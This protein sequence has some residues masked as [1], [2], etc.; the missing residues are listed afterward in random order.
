MRGG[1]GGGGRGRTEERLLPR[2]S[3]SLFMVSRS[4]AQRWKEGA[5]G[6]RRESDR[7][8]EREGGRRESILRE[9]TSIPLGKEVE[10]V[11]EDGGGRWGP[12]GWWSLFSGRGP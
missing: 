9:M 3:T 11:G 7:E 6:R 1:E 10:E 5:D 4:S 2:P 8:R 12:A